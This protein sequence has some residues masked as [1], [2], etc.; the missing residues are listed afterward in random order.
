MTRPRFSIVTPVFDPSPALFAR[1]WDSVRE[2]VE[3]EWEW[4]LVDDASR[5]P[6]TAEAL[7]RI[8]AEDQRVR[9]ERRGVNV[10]IEIGRAHV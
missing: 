5:N 7:E 9:V 10:G 1:T 4:C 2:Q 3:A 8:A 6:A